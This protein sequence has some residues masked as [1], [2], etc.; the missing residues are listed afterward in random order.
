MKGWLRVTINGR[1]IRL[2]TNAICWF[3]EREANTELT[4]IHLGAGDD[5]Y[6]IVDQSY[7]ALCTAIRADQDERT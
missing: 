2:R 7:S 5:D 3:T 6:I 4:G 1:P